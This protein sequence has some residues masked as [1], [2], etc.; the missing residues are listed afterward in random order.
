MQEYMNLAAIDIGSNAARL[1]IS[2]VLRSDG[3]IYTKKVEYVRYPLQLGKDVFNEG[4]IG[5]GRVDKLLKLMKIFELLMEI[6]EVE[7]YM[8]CATSAMRNAVNG[9]ELQQIIEERTGIH[10]LIISGED[11][12]SLINDIVFEGLDDEV[13]LHIDVGGGS[14]ELNLFKNQ[15]KKASVSFKMGSL[16]RSSEQAVEEIWLAIQGWIKDQLSDTKDITCIGTGGNISKIFSILSDRGQAKD[17]KRKISLKHMEPLVEE[18]A[19]MTF[20][21]RMRTFNLNPDRSD[22]IVPAGKIYMRVME[23][24]S[25]KKII[26]PNIGLKDGMIRHLIRKHQAALSTD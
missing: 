6:N 10:V 8:A 7:D 5:E 25:C 1:Q 24:A 3:S 21:E 9:V 19:A 17:K 13:Y 11:E 18:L 4:H 2:R 14:T 26:V 22:V 15:K 20:T 12:A 16:R 23:L